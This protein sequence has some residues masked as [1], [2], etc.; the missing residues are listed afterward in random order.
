[1]TKLQYKLRF[2]KLGRLASRI[3]SYM[4]IHATTLMVITLV[5][6][7]TLYVVAMAYP[8]SGYTNS[9]MAMAAGYHWTH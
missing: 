4:A 9:S 3:N 1:M 5:A 8:V 2:S 6:M 7:V